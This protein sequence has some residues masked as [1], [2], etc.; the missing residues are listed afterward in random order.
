MRLLAQARNPYSRS[1]LWIPGSRLFRAPA[2]RA[3]QVPW[4]DQTKRNM[5]VSSWGSLSPPDGDLLPARD[6]MTERCHD[7]TDETDRLPPGPELL[8]L[9]SLLATSFVETELVLTRI[10]RD[11]RTHAGAGKVPSR[12]L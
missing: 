12:V 9:S 10:L 3:L 7:P 11:H 6:G 8:E 1:W 2:T 5:V 4:K